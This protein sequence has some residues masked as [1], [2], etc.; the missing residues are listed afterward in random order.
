MDWFEKLTGFRET[1]YEDTRGKLKVKGGRLLSTV[2]SASYRIGALESV[3]LQAL[4]ER[5]RAASAPPS[6]LK[7]SVVTGDVRRMHHS[8]DNAGALFQVA[9]Q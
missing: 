6:R 3:S 9:S 4:R 7:V 8:P 1:S 5:A 2:S